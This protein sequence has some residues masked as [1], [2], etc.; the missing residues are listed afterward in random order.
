[1]TPLA[2]LLLVAIVVSV[3][4]P[5]A[6]AAAEGC[7]ARNVRPDYA[8][9]VVDG[10]LS[11]PPGDPLYGSLYNVT[12]ASVGAPGASG[13][14]VVACAAPN[15]VA[16]SIAGAFS[17]EAC[18]QIRFYGSEC[19]SARMGFVGG[20]SSVAVGGGGGA[21]VVGEIPVACQWP[22]KSGACIALEGLIGA[23]CA[24]ASSRGEGYATVAD[25]VAVLVGPPAIAAAKCESKTIAS[26]YDVR[27][28]KGLV[29][30]Y[31]MSVTAQE[32]DAWRGAAAAVG[33][34]LDTAGAARDLEAQLREGIVVRAG[35]LEVAR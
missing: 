26:V 25:G 30:E 27:E 10:V 11:D 17:A 21:G 22:G 12:N 5:V 13:E 29:E 9:C 35:H 28:A 2:R 7:P 14:F 19:V 33:F 15:Y 31:L 18:V 4:W 3:G 1:M 32:L 34:A 23:T 6:P 8:E 20:G 24:D 16:C